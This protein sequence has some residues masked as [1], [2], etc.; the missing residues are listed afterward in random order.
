MISSQSQISGPL[1]ALM[2]L[3]QAEQTLKQSAS[4]VTSS[5]QP[6][7]AS[8]AIQSAQALTQPGI[9]DLLPGVRQQAAMQAQ[10]QQPVTQAQLAQAMQRAQPSQGIAAG[11]QDVRMAEGGIVGYSGTGESLVKNL[12]IDE[13]NRMSPEMR[14]AYFKDLMERRGAAGPIPTSVGAAPVG[15][16]SLGGALKA[17][18]TRFAPLALLTDLFTTSDEDVALL[19]Q[20]EAE[21]GAAT[22]VDTLKGRPRGQADYGVEELSPPQEIRDLLAKYPGKGRR[23]PA[24]ET[25]PQKTGS[26][27][28]S[29]SAPPASDRVGIAQIPQPKWASYL[30]NAIDANRSQIL[31][32]KI[33]EQRAEEIRREALIRRGIDPD[34][35]KVRQREIDELQSAYAKE[36]ADR[37]KMVEGRGLENLIGFLTRAGGAKSLARGLG[38]ASLGMESVVEKQRLSDQEFRR[39]MMERQKAIGDS[40][41]AVQQF[42]EAQALGDLKMQADSTKDYNEAI[43]KQ[44]ATEAKMYGDVVPSM[45]QSET[46]T[47]DRASRERIEAA[48]AKRQGEGQDFARLSGLLSSLERGKQDDLLK[49]T[50]AHKKSKEYSLV[51]TLAG[52]GSTMTTAQQTIYDK[53]QRELANKIN[54]IN[55]AYS[56]RTGPIEKKLYGAPINSLDLSQ[57]TNFSVSGGS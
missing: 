55:S 4:P 16:G 36:E 49:V 32:E 34:Y 52:T 43:N 29:A 15:S 12:S 5:G 51:Y 2:Q 17:G 53:A 9:E 6:T 50:E 18:L 13:I 30:Q 3:K 21:R 56:K 27:A 10:A 28:S 26:A 48:Q 20:A 39:L 31:P 1:A 23:G 8:Q 25:P 37:A 54:D 44:K 35:Y 47:A 33:T 41:A 45:I 7:V 24:A 57:W 11:P 46:A 40:R 22:A 38:Q 14:K 42:R 19:K